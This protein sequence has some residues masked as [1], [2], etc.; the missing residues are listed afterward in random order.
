MLATMYPTL[1]TMYK[2]WGQHV[3]SMLYDVTLFQ[4]LLL[5]SLKSHDQYCDH[6][7]RCDCCDSVTD[8]FY[9]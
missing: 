7:I 1:M 2:A 8:H 4:N 9:P 5:S 6:T 3:V